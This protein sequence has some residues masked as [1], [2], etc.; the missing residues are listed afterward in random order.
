MI[1]PIMKNKIKLN[2]KL[3][4]KENRIEIINKTNQKTKIK[5]NKAV[6]TGK[7]AIK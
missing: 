3:A 4:D 6:K 1:I 5:T 2:I 7:G